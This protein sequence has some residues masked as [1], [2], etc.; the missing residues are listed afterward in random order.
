M[1]RDV[2][3]RGDDYIED[4]AIILLFLY[5]SWKQLQ[6]TCAMLPKGS[7]STTSLTA[8]HFSDCGKETR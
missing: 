7:S 1:L 3:R 8:S 6:L 4:S 5:K 2:Q